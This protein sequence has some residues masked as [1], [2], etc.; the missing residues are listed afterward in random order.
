[1][2]VSKTYLE[3][4]VKEINQVIQML[5]NTSPTHPDLPEKKANRLYYVNKLVE[6]D[7]LGLNT[8]KV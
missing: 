7:E 3:A 6:M 4:R 5:E 1:M 2:K 8:I